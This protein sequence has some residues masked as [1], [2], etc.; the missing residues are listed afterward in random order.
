MAIN[1]P[2]STIN[3]HTDRIVLVLTL[4]EASWTLNFNFQFFAI[5]KYVTYFSNFPLVGRPNFGGTP[6][7]LWIFFCFINV[8]MK[9]VSFFK[10]LNGHTPPKWISAKSW[11]P[12]TGVSKP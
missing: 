6:F 3:L 11:K 7:K 12:S 5:L 9:L 2:N 8:Q 4:I 10:I 1:H